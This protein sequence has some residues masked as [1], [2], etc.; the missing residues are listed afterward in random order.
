MNIYSRTLLS[1]AGMRAKRQMISNAFLT[2]GAVERS[3]NNGNFSNEINEAEKGA[4]AF[5]PFESKGVFWTVPAP[6]KGEPAVYFA[7]IGKHIKIGFSTDVEQR[8]RSFTT[9]TAQEISLLLTIS[10]D[11]GVERR[12]H[13]LLAVHFLGRP[14][15][16][17]RDRKAE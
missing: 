4:G 9:G 7:R 12:L 10:G 16:T 13:R 15:V 3:T 8:M 5:R 6:K 11:H 17:I 1:G 14:D 2:D